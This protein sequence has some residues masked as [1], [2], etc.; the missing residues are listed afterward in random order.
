[1]TLRTL[2]GIACLA[3]AA[4]LAAPAEGSGSPAHAVAKPAA[5]QAAAPSAGGAP[6]VVPRSLELPKGKLFVT[7]PVPHVSM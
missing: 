2:C 6:A 3:A 4:P 5:A 1:M 7:D